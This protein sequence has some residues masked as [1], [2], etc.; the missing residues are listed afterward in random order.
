MART[1]FTAPCHI[2]PQRNPSGNTNIQPDT[3][4]SL[5]YGGG[6]IL[7]HRMR[8]NVYTGLGNGA[9]AGVV[10]WAND[11]P[12]AIDTIIASAPA[13][14]T[15][16][17]AAAANVVSGTAMTLT[18]ATTLT[19]GALVTAAALTT[20]PFTTV[21]PK[22][23]VVI[24]SQMAYSF[25]GL[26]DI[27]AYYDPTKA[28]SQV[29]AVTGVASG[30]GGAFA[31]TGFDVYGQPMHET[32]TATAGATTVSGKKAW[33]WITSIVPQFSDAHNYSFDVTNVFGLSIA[34]DAAAYVDA[35]VAGTGFTNNPSVTAADTTSP[36]TAT[37]GDVRGT[38]A[39]TP[40]G[41][42]ITVFIQP[43]S[44][45]LTTLMATTGVFGVTNF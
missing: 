28:V 37:T 13:A 34:V 35:W 22:G 11:T 8:Y 24:Q 1:A 18:A 44:A 15:G 29:I 6:G 30:T 38:L 14:G 20:F 16:G 12:C 41:N 21:I 27:T 3:A 36:A 17:I 4:T 7:D 42:R 23:T 33:K 45:R 5:N 32:V 2:V 31:I 43:S 39:I 10:G 9:L 26:R 25:V 40:G 19:N